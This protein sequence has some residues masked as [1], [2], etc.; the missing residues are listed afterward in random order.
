MALCGT[1]RL[2]AARRGRKAGAVLPWAKHHFS[3]KFI[4]CCGDQASYGLDG[5]IDA[6]L[7][8]DSLAADRMLHALEG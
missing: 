8:G 2:L 1:D 6:A 7:A 4:A 3:G 5:V